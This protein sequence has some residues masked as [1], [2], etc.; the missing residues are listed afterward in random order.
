MAA[1][2]PTD[3]ILTLSLPII[4][5][6]QT[7]GGIPTIPIPP[8]LQGA[9]PQIPTQQVPAIVNNQAPV[10]TQQVPTIVQ[11][12]IR[13]VPIQQ[14]GAVPTIV[15]AQEVQSQRSRVT[16]LAVRQPQQAPAPNGLQPYQTVEI[17]GIVTKVTFA[18]NRGDPTE[19]R[20]HCPNIGKN[21]DAVCN[22]FCPL[23]ENDTIHAMCMVSLDGKLHLNKQPFIQCPIDKDSMIQCFMR[24]L[25]VGYQPTMRIYNTIS[26]IAGGDD[27]VIG[28]L[29]GIAQSWN[30]TRNSEILFMFGATEAE[31]VKK[32]LGFWH[33]ERNLR[34]LYLFGLNKKEINACRMT[35]DQIYQ[36][37]MENP[38]TVPGIPIEK[39]D[40]ILDRLNKR[41]PDADRIR[42]AIVRIMWKN[43]HENGWTGTPT[44]FLSRQFPSIRDHVDALKADYGLVAELE[45]AYLQFPHRVETWVAEYVI[46]KIQQ[47]PITYDMPLDT[48]I[49][50]PDGRII[51]RLSAHFTREMSEEQ[52][53][54]VQGA[55]DHTITIITGGAGVGK[56]LSFGTPILM[57]DGTIKKI[58]EIVT[59]EFVMGPDSRPR[60]VLSTCMGT[61]NMFEIIPKKGRSFV[62]NTP[63]VL[64]LKGIMP[65]MEYQPERAKKYIARYSIRG[66]RKTKAFATELEAL[67][68][69]DDLPEDIFD[70]PLDEFMRRSAEQQQHSHLFHVGVEFPARDL[71]IDPYLFGQ[72][73]KE[74]IPD[75]YKINS[76][77]N[78]LRLLD[79]ILETMATIYPD[80][81][82]LMLESARL[83]DDIEYLAFSLGLMV[84]RME[85][86][87][88]AIQQLTIMAAETGQTVQ[89][90]QI[91]S[92]GLGQY[93]GFE[94]D[95]DGRFLLGDFLVTHNTSVL[96][97]IVHNLELRG[98]TYAVCA[99][100]GKAVARIREVTKKR[101]PSTIHRLIANT[102]KNHLDVRST[103]FEKDIPLSEYEYVVMDEGSTTTTELTYDFLQ[104]YPNIKHLILIG[105]VNQLPPIG[106]GSMFYELVKSETVPTY[107]LTTNYRVYTTNGQ[108]DGVIM[109]ANAII[110]HDRN[111]PFEFIPTDNFTIVDGPIERVYDIVRG[112]F[113]ANILPEQI[114]IL[115][116]VKSVLE[117]LNRTFQD[118]YNV[119]ARYVT[120][121]RGVKWM[122]GDRVMLTSNEM[123]I[124]VFNGEQGTVRDITDKAILIDFGTSGCHEFLLEPSYDERINVPQG[125]A[126]PYWR[127]GQMVEQVMDG[128]EGDYS[129]ELT[130]KKLDH[131]YAITIDKSQG[132]EWDFVILCI[133]EFNTGSFLN[134]NRIYTAITRTK[135]ACWCVVADIESFNTV[136]VKAPGF[137]CENLAKRLTARLPNLKPYQLPP[138]VQDLEMKNDLQA[139]DV[140]ADYFEDG[141][142]FDD[143]E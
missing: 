104:A 67:H 112:C 136:A 142:D 66:L 130:V 135:R 29:S 115:S 141:F 102:K 50:L 20:I 105:D 68:F 44:R 51:E 79:G 26:R 18:K 5:P 100:V 83:A 140:P 111:Y 88:D 15:P 13:L 114:V 37:C 42:G 25:R 107:R 33:R 24:A 46:N 11:P 117:Q 10:P 30:D 71:P 98:V 12:P 9:I 73:L 132:S 49:T 95:G 3:D 60:Q 64:T 16:Q 77:S 97:Q 137:R 84:T 28:F 121:S 72:T 35:C 78:R 38:Y 63:H 54:A 87:G 85:C 34:R 74:K 134:M 75:I 118:I 65:H 81:F 40:A 62:C 123:S 120:D 99:Y 59:G 127:R 70:I 22:L 96:G 90:F 17:M 36:R 31:D 47:D 126:A 139:N 21:F 82:E 69:M 76:R 56:C 52:Q 39:C 41:P 125:M 23:R 110:N 14:P 103:Q 124:G 133:Q 109:N 7:T 4:P 106:W 143:Y 6:L 89:R 58:E 116:P 91:Q 101:N 113:S 94:L 108:R 32:L 129:D 128:D 57:F 92:L 131:A 53:R 61:D 27:Q 93:C 1:I 55:L 122:I 43:L 119:G 86:F 19:F 80:R 2:I 48:K 8:H 138:P 45:T